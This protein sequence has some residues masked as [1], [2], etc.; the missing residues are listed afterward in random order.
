[1]RLGHA[2]RETGARRARGGREAGARRARG[3]RETGA[4]RA[5]DERETSERRRET[6]AGRAASFFFGV[7][8][9]LIMTFNYLILWVR[10]KGQG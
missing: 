5:R 9:W 10:V 2:G 7:Y 6:G 1:M 3:G 8:S 4:R